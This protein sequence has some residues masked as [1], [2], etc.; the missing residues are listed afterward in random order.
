MT[1]EQAEAV[2]QSSDKVRAA[3]VEDF[4]GVPWGALQA[5]DLVINTGK[6]SPDLAKTWIVDAARASDTMLEVDQPT[7]GSIEGGLLE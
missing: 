4:Y 7:T 5:F 2:V 1:V 6:I 3:F